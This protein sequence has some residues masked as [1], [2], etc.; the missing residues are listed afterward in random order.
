M[1][2]AGHN[3]CIIAAV[4]RLCTGR[5]ARSACDAHIRN[6]EVAEPGDVVKRRENHR[7]L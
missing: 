5:R 1:S 7:L 2:P 6:A 3:M 4:V